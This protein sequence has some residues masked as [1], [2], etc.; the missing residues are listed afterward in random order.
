[1]ASFPQPKALLFHFDAA[2][3]PAHG[4]NFIVV[5]EHT[6]DDEKAWASSTTPT[7]H[8]KF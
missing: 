7:V 4:V 6:E 3:L 1:M 8:H 5:L 2:F